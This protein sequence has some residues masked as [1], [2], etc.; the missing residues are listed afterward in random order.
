MVG[1]KDAKDESSPATA[2]DL[3][4]AVRSTKA[5]DAH[6]SAAPP[7]IVTRPDEPLQSAG[8]PEVPSEIDRPGSAARPDLEGQRPI[9]PG[10]DASTPKTWLWIAAA[11]VLGVVVAVAGAAILMRQ[12][13]QDLA[14]KPPAE[15]P[16]PCCS[17]S[18]KRRS[19]NA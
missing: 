14:I 7:V 15:A 5:D 12:K 10:V 18:P 4:K 16:S 17:R 8:A 11:V 9:A 3:T 13:P 1:V 6:A 19:P 2:L